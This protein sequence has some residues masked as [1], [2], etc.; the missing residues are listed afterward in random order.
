MAQSD[1]AARRASEVLLARLAAKT[2]CCLITYITHNCTY[3]EIASTADTQTSSEL[4]V[5]ER[6]NNLSPD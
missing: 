2:V 4:A 6:T 1:A 5:D 3:V